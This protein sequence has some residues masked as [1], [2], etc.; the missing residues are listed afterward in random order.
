M[1]RFHV[2]VYVCPDHQTD[3]AAPIMLRC[4]RPFQSVRPDFLHD[5]TRIIIDM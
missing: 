1:S 4:L 3:R 2:Y 5:R